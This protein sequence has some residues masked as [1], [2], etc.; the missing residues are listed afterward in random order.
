MTILLMIHCESY[1]DLLLGLHG[2]VS[3]R[4]IDIII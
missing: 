4:V 1:M 3:T 2:K